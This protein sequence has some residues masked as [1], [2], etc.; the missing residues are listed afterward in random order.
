M[1][2]VEE[3][4]LIADGEL[5][6]IHGIVGVGLMQERERNKHDDDED[7]NVEMPPSTPTVPDGSRPAGWAAG[8][9]QGTGRTLSLQRA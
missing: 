3:V 8:A 5:D 6:H 1:N 7:V 9:L 2:Q 4:E